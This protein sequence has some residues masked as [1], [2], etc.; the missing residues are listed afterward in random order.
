MKQDFSAYSYED[1]KRLV[2]N[3]NVK[4]IMTGTKTSNMTVHCYYMETKSFSVSAYKFV[5]KQHT[6]PTKHLLKITQKRNIAEN[7]TTEYKDKLAAS[8]FVHLQ[9]KYKDQIEKMNRG[10]IIKKRPLEK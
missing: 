5:N 4:Y 2:K 6:Q 9:Y 8:V 3:M 10:I 1:I 7:L